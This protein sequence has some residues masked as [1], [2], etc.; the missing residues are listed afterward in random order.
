MPDASMAGLFRQT[1]QGVHHQLAEWLR[2]CCTY[3]GIAVIVTVSMGFALP[4]LR[5][6]A[7]QVHRALST[8]L[9]PPAVSAGSADEP[10]YD[11]A[12]DTPSV[13]AMAIPAAPPSNATGYLGPLRTDLPPAPP[14]AKARSGVSGPQVEA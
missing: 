11:P 13:V 9:A 1:A 2:I 3:L 7:L 8:A 6:Q 14:K 4:G 10:A 12:Y 5:D